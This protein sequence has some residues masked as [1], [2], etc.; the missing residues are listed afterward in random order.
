MQVTYAK[1]A[2]KIH[3]SVRTIRLWARQG[4]PVGWAIGDDGQ[5]VRVVELDVAQAWARAKMKASPVHQLRM[6]AI[7]AEEMGVKP[8]DLGPVTW[9]AKRVREQA[10][11]DGLP[12]PDSTGPSVP[13]V[14]TPAWRPVTPV[15]DLP[16]FAWGVGIRCS[17]GG[18]RA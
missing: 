14:V 12:E 4:M 10:R 16:S 5:Q 13:E 8:S 15:V 2:R 7:R 9:T 1:A 6:R 18:P 3:R 17:A 11:L